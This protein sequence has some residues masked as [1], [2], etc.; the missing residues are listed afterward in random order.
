MYIGMRT[1]D[2]MRGRCLMTVLEEYAQHKIYAIMRT[3]KTKFRIKNKF[4]N[5]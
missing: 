2:L 1:K 5:K 3:L 4:E